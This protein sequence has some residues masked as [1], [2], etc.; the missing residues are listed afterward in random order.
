MAKNR[1]KTDEN[2][3]KLDENTTLWCDISKVDEEK[4]EVYGYA[5][6]WDVDGQGEVITKAAIEYAV[7]D[8]L[9]WAN[10]R[11]M[12]QPSAVGTVFKSEID[13]TGWFIGAKVV[14]DTAWDKV[15]NKV[16]K[17][18]S[19]GGRSRERIGN[20]ITKM[21]VTEISLADRPVNGNSVITLY[22]AEVDPGLEKALEVATKPLDPN[23]QDVQKNLGTYAISRLSDIIGAVHSFREFYI[24]EERVEGDSEGPVPKMLTRTLAQLGRILKYIV[25]EEMEEII[26]DEPSEPSHPYNGEEIAMAELNAADVARLIDEALDRRAQSE[27]A[28]REAAVQKAEQDELKKLV[29]SALEENKVLKAEIDRLNSTPA[30]GKG[31]AGAATV[32]TKEGDG[33]DDVK[34]AIMPESDNPLDLIRAA[35]RVGVVQTSQG[36][37]PFVRN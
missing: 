10:L 11:E 6:T 22:K 4:R 32:V 17:G 21:V 37:V 19:V 33:K 28:Q 31:V 23:D 1:G 15:V 8:Y 13:E 7:D 2:V 25:R 16:Y 12:H 24:M 5:V 9:K 27:A 26:N 20:K 3:Q 30:E 35:H 36:F 18:F 14:D 34:K 29:T